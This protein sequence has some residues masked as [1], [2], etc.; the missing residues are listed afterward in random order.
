MP[1][2]S[3][4]VPRVYLSLKQNLYFVMRKKKE[5]NLI[6][7]PDIRILLITLPV[8]YFCSYSQRNRDSFPTFLELHGWTI[9]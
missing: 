8:V 4:Q 5:V 6:Q 3:Y 1:D 7:S 2:R 9:V